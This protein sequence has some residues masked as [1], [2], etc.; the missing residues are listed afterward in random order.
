MFGR[1]RTVV[2]AALAGA[3][4]LSVPANA[5]IPVQPVPRA[6]Y[7]GVQLFYN[8]DHTGG[9][10]QVVKAVKGC[11]QVMNHPGP[12]L[13]KFE[14]LG[15][16]SSAYEMSI[17]MQHLHGFPPLPF[18]TEARFFGRVMTE[19]KGA[20]VHPASE[21]NKLMSGILRL[22]GQDYHQIAAGAAS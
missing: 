11:Y 7:I 2:L 3:G 9:M 15:E 1:I 4:A 10:A 17:A 14:C 19:L 5:A 20:G 13:G 6:I 22:A 18:Y 16:D 8:Y 21:R 12:T